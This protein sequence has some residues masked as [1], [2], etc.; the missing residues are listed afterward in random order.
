MNWVTIH[1]TGNT[2][3]GANARAHSSYLKGNTAAGI[4]VSW[5]YTVD[6]GEVY[7]HLPENETAFHAGDGAN[8]VGNAQSI[9]IEICVNSDGD[10]AAAV[11]RA[12]ALVADICVRRNISAD[13]VVQHNRWNG[14]NCPANLRGGRPFP[15][16]EF[17]SRVRALTE[18]APPEIPEPPPPPLPPETVMYRVVAGSF[19]KRANALAQ[20]KRLKAKGFDSFIVEYKAEK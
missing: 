2:S 12:I 4:P 15:W 7:R 13:C 19:A 5:H 16:S 8:G 3:R 9:G 17:C 1:E 20:V 10:F 14:K 18:A 6:S 11:E